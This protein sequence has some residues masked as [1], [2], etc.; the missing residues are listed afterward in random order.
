MKR[1]I[2]T[3]AAPDRRRQLTY[4]LI[5]IIPSVGYSRRMVYCPDNIPVTNWTGVWV[6]LLTG[7]VTM[8][9]ISV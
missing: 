8:T 2:F 4:V 9:V 7:T 1:A 3:A 6:T 5:A